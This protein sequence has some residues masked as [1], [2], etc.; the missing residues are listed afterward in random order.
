MNPISQ[1]KKF[2]YLFGPVISRRLGISLGVDLLPPK[3]CQFN[4]VYCEAGATT[5][6][7]PER[8]EFFPLDEVKADIDKFLQ[9]R[10]DIDYLT[11]SG[12]GEPTLYLR[13]GELIDWL[14]EKHSAQKI[15]LLTNGILIGEGNIPEELKNLDLI[16][17]SLDAADENSF[18]KI[19]RPHRGLSL[20]KLVNSIKNFRARNKSQMWL[21]I[22]VVPGLNDSDAEIAKF[23]EIVR[24]I[25]PDKI[26]LNGLDRPGV[27]K[28]V[29]KPNAE[30]LEKFEKTLSLIAPTEI[31]VRN[32]NSAKI[33]NLYEDKTDSICRLVE[34]RPCTIEEIKKIFSINSEECDKII[35]QLLNSNKYIL[36][37]MPDGVFLK[38]KF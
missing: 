21:E 7:I 14:K 29:L 19:N 8:K 12:A 17:P 33:A 26:Q 10:P 13:L 37:K 30:I 5:N 9:E 28:F 22:F 23:A 34:R 35:D 15:C 3:T 2:K 38:K 11:F 6:L 4:C 18:K 1:D 36:E 20:A 31:I 27:E 25:M 16:V 24:E 32:I